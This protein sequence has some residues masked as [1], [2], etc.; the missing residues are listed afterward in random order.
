MLQ[1]LYQDAWMVAVN[2]PSGLLVHRSMIDR[3][4]TQFAMQMVR[5]QIG[6]RVYPV[7]RLDRPTSGVLLMALSSHGA[8]L[9]S[10]IIE[11][12][13]VAKTYLAICRGHL[14]DE[15]VIDHPL[16]ENLDKIADRHKSGHNLPKD[17]I[18]AY[19][20]IEQSEIPVAIN[21]YPSSRFSLLQLNP[22]HGRKHQIRRHLAHLRHPILCDVNY[23]D[24]KYNRY[25]K[26]QLADA[27]L[28]LHASRLELPHPIN[29]QMLT[30]DAPLDNSFKHLLN[31]VNI[32]YPR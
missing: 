2:K 5:D 12:R 19:R 21:R 27:R 4:E 25:F 23:G 13:K 22:V 20:C 18:T 16:S 31:A 26:A 3:H 10:A 28:A 17:A 14:N 24:N 1:I 8:K 9:I 11:A 29:G 6:Q 15:G 7:H 32:E 30:I